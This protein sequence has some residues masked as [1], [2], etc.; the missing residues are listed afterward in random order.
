[1]ELKL[2]EEAVDADKNKI[3]I[4]QAVPMLQSQNT[5]NLKHSAQHI[6]FASASV[7]VSIVDDIK[8]EAFNA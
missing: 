3:L 5:L 7:S 6:G 8:T 4:H 2:I 1:M